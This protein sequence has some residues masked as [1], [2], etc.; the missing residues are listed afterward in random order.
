METTIKKLNEEQQVAFDLVRDTNRSFFLTGKAGTGKTTFVKYIQETLTDKRFVIVAPTGLAAITA[1]GQTIHSFFGLPLDPIAPDAEF[2][3]F[4]INYEKQCLLQKVDTI[5]MDEVSMVKCDIVDAVDSILRHVMKNSM[6]FGGKQVIFIGDLYQ[7]D[8]IVDTKDE[9]LMRF[10]KYYYNTTIPYFFKA[11]VFQSYLLPSIEFSKVYRQKDKEFLQMLEHIRIGKYVKEEI[12]KINISSMVN[13]L[14]EDYNKKEN[15][16]LV[17]TPFNKK[18]DNINERELANIPNQAYTYI[19]ELEGDFNRKNFPAPYELTL[20]EGAQVMFCRNDLINHQWVNGTL[21]VVSSLSE[22]SI[23]VKIDD[24]E[25]KVAKETWEAVK[26]VFNEKTQKLDKEVIGTY[27]QYPLK[28]AWAITIHKSQGL[29]FD[30]VTLDPNGIFSPGQLYVALSRVRSLEGLTLVNRVY[31]NYI[32]VKQDINTFMMQY[33]NLSAIQNDIIQQKPITDAITK[34]DY[35]AA[36]SYLL[37][38]VLSAVNDSNIDKAWHG[39]CQM[40]SVLYN[41]DIFTMQ[42]TTEWL[43]GDDEKT[44]FLNTIIA[45]CNRKYDFAIALAE[46]GCNLNVNSDFDYLKCIAL[47]MNS[48]YDEA[49]LALTEWKNKL[50]EHNR[51]LDDRYYY[52]SAWINKKQ[53]KQYISA[54]Q[55]VIRH[56][57]RYITPLLFLKESM[58]A[59]GLKLETGDDNS[60]LVDMFNQSSTNQEFQIA[61]ENATSEGRTILILAVLDYPYEQ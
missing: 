11:R 23:F 34:C 59:A 55:H 56:T 40:M 35:D 38:Q 4:N 50:K 20:K 5:I 7:L 10:Y 45:I 2:E 3:M 19:G 1:G 15:K 52:L 53:G 22:D 44:L 9:G 46:R 18:A 12:D 58:N 25:I 43:S 26:Y 36:A 47:F 54:T 16:D 24:D 13:L 32:Y 21:G 8:P 49:E 33:S 29:T 17:L 60:R 61:W 28:L 41:L 27:T 14:T 42:E 51:V 57:P 39:A 31:Q 30:R 37:R 6:P 48:N